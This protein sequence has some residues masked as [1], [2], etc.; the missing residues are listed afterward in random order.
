MENLLKSD[1]SDTPDMQVIQKV[2]QLGKIEML[3]LSNRL[4][5]PLVER[6]CL[7][8]LRAWRRD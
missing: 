7:W 5:T 6:V 4:G 2:G 1:T 3:G 8:P